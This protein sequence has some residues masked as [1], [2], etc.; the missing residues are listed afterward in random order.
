[1]LGMILIGLGIISL[2]I[3]LGNSAEWLHSKTPRGRREER[4]LNEKYERR[5]ELRKE[6]E[7]LRKRRDELQAHARKNI[8]KVQIIN[9]REYTI[10]SYPD[11]DKEVERCNNRIDEIKRELE[12]ENFETPE[13]GGQPEHEIPGMYWN[14]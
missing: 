6:I 8:G 1:M 7:R 10:E 14:Q 13:A 11:I 2:I 5:A 4:E 9:G 12:P 3:W